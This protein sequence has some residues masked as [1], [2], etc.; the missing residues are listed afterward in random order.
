MLKYAIVTFGCRVNQADS[1]RLE[2][3]LSARG[4]LAVAPEH[5]DLVLVNTCSVTATADQ[6][7]RQAIRRIH[8]LN[9]NARIVATGCHATREP[10]AVGALPGVAAV[11]SNDGK[12][13]LATSVVE[14]TG[15]DALTAERFGNGDGP[16]GAALAP[17]LAGRT[18]WTLRVQTGCDETCA[19]CIVPTTRGRSRSRP[20]AEIHREL[21]QLAEAGF[22]EVVLT[23]VHLGAYGRDLDPQVSLAGLLR[24]T[25]TRHRSL[26]F[27]VSSL[28]PMD[29]AP[30]IVELVAS[31][32]VF[33]PHLHLPLQHGCDEVLAAM[34]R[35]YTVDS[36]RRKV[37]L[38]RSRLPDAAIGSDVIVGYP[39]ETDRTFETSLAYLRESPLTHLHVFAYSDR[40]GTD[41][42]RLPDKVHGSI[43][44]ERAAR[45]RE[46]GRDLATRFRQSQAGSIRRALT[47]D[48]GTSAVT[49]N[50]IKVKVPPGRG[51]NEWITVRL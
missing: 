39:G 22:K 6:G 46:V 45:V 33:A 11:V 44:R 2:A 13:T 23:G 30:E 5:A 17:G 49:D 50:Y 14:M 27:R 32:G 28:E 43:V 35:P 20:Q 10:D 48:D 8:R 34:R 18:A 9:P 26:F 29:L 15:A 31:A 25:A 41:A 12:D 16:C 19:Y 42:S 36:Y 7:T 37:D 51:R 21:E 24:E 47:I 40:P 1:L 4:G 3:E 38:V